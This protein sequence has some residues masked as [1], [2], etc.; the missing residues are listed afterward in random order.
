MATEPADG[1]MR[2]EHGGHEYR[3]RPDPDGEVE[4]A[5]DGAP[6]IR[7]HRQGDEV[8]IT[9]TKGRELRRIDIAKAM[10]SAPTAVTH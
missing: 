9:D 3:L 2:F 4:V 5:R 10:A 6:V 1:S 8:I 7:Y